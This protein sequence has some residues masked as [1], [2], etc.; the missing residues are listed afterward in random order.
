VGLS[1]LKSID[2]PNI[3]FGD[4]FPDLFANYLNLL[5][6]LSSHPSLKVRALTLKYWEAFLQSQPVLKFVPLHSFSKLFS[7]LFPCIFS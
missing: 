1:Q 4:N 6:Q 2:N 5:M 7:S 3:K